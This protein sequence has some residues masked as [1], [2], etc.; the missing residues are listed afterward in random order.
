MDFNSPLAISQGEFN[1]QIKFDIANPEYF[2]SAKTGAVLNPADVRKP[3]ESIPAQLPTGTSEAPMRESANNGSKG[4]IAVAIVQIM[5]QA[6]MKGSID[7][8][9]NLVYF[10]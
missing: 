5:F 1:Y 8:I 2:A 4:T 6:A 10:L 3:K 9:M 7:R